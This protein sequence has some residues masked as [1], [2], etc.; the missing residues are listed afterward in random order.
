VIARG[1]VFQ[2]KIAD[3]ILR[4]MGLLPA[5]RLSR[6]G[7]ESFANNADTFEEVEEELLHNGTV[8]I[9]PEGQHQDKRWL[10]KFSSG[11]LRLCFE[12]AEKS[13][14]EKEIF[15]LPVCNHYS[16]YFGI[17]EDVIFKYGKPIPISPYYESYKTQPRR[18]QR[19]LNE[20]VRQQVL[21]LMLHV[22]DL[23]N[24]TAID[25]LRNTYG[26]K[27][28]KEH[29]FNPNKL[30]EK[31]LS[32]KELIAKLE[33][34]KQENESLL[35]PI[36]EQILILKE[37]TEQHR[38]KDWQFDIPYI[39]W[40][41]GL[42]SVWFV[43]LSPLFLFSLIPNA[44]VLYA[45][46]VL[47]SKV[48][49]PMFHSAIRLCTSV[50]FTVPLLFFLIFGLTWIFS[51]V[52]WIALVYFLSLPALGVFAWHY[53]QLWRQRKDQIKFHRLIKSNK[54]NDLVNIRSHIFKS[55]DNILK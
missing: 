35:L 2:N 30:P 50:L 45:P 36:Y 8:I 54:I 1:D 46:N 20:E 48:K 25:Y 3:K 44:L 53:K 29:G 26:V 9:F 10:G 13:N 32:D 16:D 27:Y 28:A 42:L 49:D 11:Y 22:D 24:Y 23:E 14:F 18:T 31:L 38:I 37:K 51:G 7:E 52:F 55:L 39:P 15:I 41:I 12:A 33:T 4:W 6:E 34:I 19:K 43:L 47:T 40:K 17:Q 5:Y 21:D